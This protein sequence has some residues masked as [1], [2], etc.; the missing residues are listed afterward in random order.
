M[1]YEHRGTPPLARKAFIFRFLR[2]ALI[3]LVLVVGSLFFGMEGYHHFEGLRWTDAYLNA[4]MLL[5]GMGPVNDPQTFGGK[6]FAGCYALFAG[7]VFIF[8]T[9]VLFAPVLHRILHRLHWE[10]DHPS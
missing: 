5:G 9:G 10:K 7:L 6:I 1:P 8:V 2:H 4:A 3:A